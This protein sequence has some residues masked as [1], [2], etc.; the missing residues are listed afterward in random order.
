[1]EEKV[2]LDSTI[3]S[4]INGKS[5]QFNEIKLAVVLKMTYNLLLTRTKNGLLILTL[6]K[7]NFSLIIV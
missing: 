1:M 2:Y 6:S 3:Y 5:D 7:R 4:C